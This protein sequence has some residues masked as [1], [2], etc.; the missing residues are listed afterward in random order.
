MHRPVQSKYV[1]TLK[2]PAQIY[3]DPEGKMNAYGRLGGEQFLAFPDVWARLPCTSLYHR[4][5]VNGHF[6]SR[7]TVALL[8]HMKHNRKT[9]NVPLIAT[10]RKSYQSVS[11]ICGLH[12]MLRIFQL[13]CVDDSRNTILKSVVR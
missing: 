3:S 5:R 13:H 12:R 10:G 7:M 2:L 11:C 1:Y 6:K 9:L 8:L 4:R